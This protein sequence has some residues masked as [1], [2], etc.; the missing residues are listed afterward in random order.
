MGGISRVVAR[1]KWWWK[2]L[3]VMRLHHHA[4]IGVSHAAAT[5]VSVEVGVSGRQAIGSNHIEVILSGIFI[6]CMSIR[7]YE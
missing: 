3:V 5:R 1:L 7:T 2:V 6:L 4:A